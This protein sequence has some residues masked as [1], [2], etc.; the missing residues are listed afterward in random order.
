MRINILLVGIILLAL[1]YPVVAGTPFTPTQIIS[2]TIPDTD[3]AQPDLI[4]RSDSN[5]LKLKLDFVVN[6][7]FPMNGTYIGYNS[8]FMF[9][10]LPFYFTKDSI[11]VPVSQVPF[12]QR[13]GLI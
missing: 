4:V 2:W 5:T 8:T 13:K 1:V 10:E 11:V 6:D 12:V 9:Y 7:T 3:H